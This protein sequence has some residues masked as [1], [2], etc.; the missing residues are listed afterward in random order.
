MLGTQ[1]MVVSNKELVLFT[2][3][4]GDLFFHFH[5]SISK[6]HSLYDT[7]SSKFKIFER[8]TEQRK[9]SCMELFRRRT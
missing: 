2:Q 1:N 7:N 8:Q 3:L 9:I 5:F 6:Q 4:L